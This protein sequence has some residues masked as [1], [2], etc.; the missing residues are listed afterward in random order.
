MERIIEKFRKKL[1]HT[2]EDFTRSLMDEIN[3]EA[4][5]IGIKG[6]RGVGKTTLMLQYIKKHFEH[7]PAVLYVS[8]DDIW[9]SDNKFADLADQFVK[10]GGKLLFLDEVHKYPGWSR[11]LKN[12][13]D[14]FPELKIVFTGSSLLEIMNARADL[15]RRATIYR[16]QGLS[17]REYLNFELGLKLNSHSLDEVLHNHLKISGEV[18]SE[19]KPI[20][21]FSQYLREGY[22]PFYKE[23][24]EL[25][26][27]RLG[28]IMNMI[29]EM[30]LPLLRGV[31][32]SYSSKLKQMLLIISES[33]P[34]IPNISKLSERIGINRNT[35][36]S[37]LSFLHEAGLLRNLYRDTHGITR[38]QKPEKI[39]LENTN[40]AYALSNGLPDKGN[41]RETF[42]ANQLSYCHSLTIPENG[43][44]LADGSKTFEIGGKGKDNK[45]LNKATVNNGFIAS[46]DIEFGNGNKIPLWMFGFLY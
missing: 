19:I 44:F 13:Y 28:E 10:H 41:I 1:S 46:D 43:D 24:P 9:F 5:M 27:S 29:I 30:E 25:Y 8:L 37:Y 35:F 21:H 6:A 18:T 39:F 40:I 36:I 23:I 11:E 12:I 26:Y 7:D 3:W 2:S 22:Y 45:Q 42:F 16:M 17:F 20:K 33:A 34:F 31:D 32:V 4:R 15:S 14:D 38:L